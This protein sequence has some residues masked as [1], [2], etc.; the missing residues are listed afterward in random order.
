MPSSLHGKTGLRVVPLTR[1][2]LESFRPLRDAVPETWT[3]DRIRMKVK[4]KVDMEMRGEE[5]QLEPGTHDVPE[6][7]AVFLAA[8]GLAAVA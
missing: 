2:A 6:Y 1:D 7:L 8:R 3:A 4:G 5:V